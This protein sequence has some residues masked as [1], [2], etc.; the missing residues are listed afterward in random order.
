MKGK[1]DAC[2]LPLIVAFKC[3][4]GQIDY[5]QFSRHLQVSAACRSRGLSKSSVQ[6]SLTLSSSIVD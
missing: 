1:V 6:T 3:R 4:V 5:S 2:C